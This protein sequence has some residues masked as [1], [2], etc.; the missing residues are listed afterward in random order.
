MMLAATFLWFVICSFFCVGVYVDLC[1]VWRYAIVFGV[2][3]EA[4][5]QNFVEKRKRKK[6]CKTKAGNKGIRRLSFYVVS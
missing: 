2:G 3:M 1:N 6:K 4:A 5:K